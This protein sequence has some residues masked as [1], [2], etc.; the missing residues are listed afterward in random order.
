MTDGRYRDQAAEQLAAPGV[1][2]RIEIGRPARPEGRRRR[3]RPA[4]VARLG[5]E[6]DDVTW[7]QQRQLRRRLVPRRRA[8]GHRGPGRGPAR[9]E[10]RRRGRPASRGRRASPTT[11][12]PTVPA[13]AGRAARPSASSASSSTPPCAGSAPTARRSRPSSASGPN[14]AKPHARPA[15][16][17]IERGRPGRARLRRPR[18]RLPLR[19]DPHRRGRRA[20]RRPSSACSTWWPTSQAAG[21]RRGAGRASTAEAV[22]ARLPRRHRRGRL[23][24]RL[25]ARHRPRRRPRHPRGARGWRRPPTA[26]LAAGHVVTVEPGVYL[27]EHG[28]VRIEDTVVVTDDGCRVAHPRAQGP[29]R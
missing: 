7:A 22:D 5:L 21:R 10:G 8:G 1:D 24:R 25:P 2:A 29:G 11:P 3:R 14:G 28:G 27:P 26:T 6:A 4:G 20:D 23:G 18:R 19:H 17:R 13:A 16:R 15:D 9:G 12:W